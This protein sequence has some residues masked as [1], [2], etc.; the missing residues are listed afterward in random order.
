MT[1]S[2]SQAILALRWYLIV[3]AFGLA[4]LPLCLRLFRHLP[5]HGHG[6]S[7]PLGLLLAGWVFWGLVTLGWL[8][9][10]AGSVLLALLIVAAAGSALYLIDRP[11]TEPGNDLSWRAIL[12]TELVFTLA[13]AAWCVVR[14]HMPRIETAGGEKW[15]EIAFLRAILRSDTFPPHDPWL[16]GFAI[17]YYYFGY[18][19]MAMITRLAGVLPSIAFNL[20]IATL[21][22]LT[23]TGAFSLVYNLVA[24]SRGRIERVGVLADR[25]NWST[26]LSGLLGPLL[27]VLMGNLEGLMEVLHARGIGS[28]AFWQWVDIRALAQK[29]PMLAEGSWLPTRFFWWWQAS[30]VIRD[31]SP[32]GDHVEVID[33]FPAFSFL[34]G[35]MHPHVLALPF[36]LLAVALALNLY[37]RALRRKPRKFELD[38]RSLLSDWPFVGWEFFVYAICLGG[39]GFLNTWDFPIYLFVVTAAYTLAHL[40]DMRDRGRLTFYALRFGLLFV[41]LLLLGFLLYQPF[42]R[43]FQ[44]QVGGIVPNLLNGTRLPQFLLM[45]GPLL[46]IAAAFVIVQA[47]RDGVQVG[48]VIKWTLIVSAGIVGVLVIVV[49]LAAVLIRAGVIAPQGIAATVDAWMRGQPLPEL[50]GEVP[51]V[52]TFVRLRILVDS[53]LLGPYPDM[54]D[55]RIVGRAILSSPVWVALGLVAFLVIIAFILQRAASVERS[56]TSVSGFVLLLLATGALLVLGVELVYI[57]DHFGTRMNT[58]FKFYFQAWILWSIGGAYAL[59]TFIRRGGAGRSVAVAVAAILICAGL[60]Y[61]T[62]AIPKRAGEQGDE[63]TLDGATYLARGRAGDYAAIAWLNEHVS[64]APV[65]LE[66]PGG[67]YVYEGRVS[68]HT[69]LPTVLGWAGHEHQWRGSYDEQ[70][71]RQADIETMYSSVDVEEV[72]TLLDKYDIRYVYVG[73]LERERYP[74]EGLAKFAGMMDTVYESGGVVIYK[75]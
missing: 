57:K 34:L 9:N 48:E 69:G 26:I 35:D 41:S 10:S 1:D 65:I 25:S 12:A 56:L 51:S 67:G 45:F 20:G 58:V 60:I 7:K 49:G 13:F 18:V 72:L 70:S 52:L 44:S 27:V 59:A 73:P 36:V 5:D 4:A 42:W 38:F 29:P 24:V 63:V 39:L 14:A 50:G 47:R 74:V 23:C 62:L 6:V 68:A 37:L 66:A 71:R 40:G 75:R 21:F 30:R 16:S 17:S 19:I 22:A 55:G 53:R 54:S 28:E 61:P 64:D 46:F 3:Q 2:A 33:E 8:H 32:A 31:Y 43:S 11:T 15:M